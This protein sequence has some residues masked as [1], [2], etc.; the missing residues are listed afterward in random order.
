[1]DWLENMSWG[2]RVESLDSGCRLVDLVTAT[3]RADAL[4]DYQEG[5]W[6][7]SCIGVTRLQTKFLPKN[8][9]V[10]KLEAAQ[11]RDTKAAQ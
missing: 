7:V 8:A 3:W 9:V 4:S 10:F 11:P 6:A 5:N 1:M 2:Y